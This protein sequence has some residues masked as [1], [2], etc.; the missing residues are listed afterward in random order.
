[1]LIL[2]ILAAAAAVSAST[3]SA[4]SG[5]NT[6]LFVEPIPR[7]DAIDDGVNSGRRR[8][9]R[10]EETGNDTVAREEDDDVREDGDE[11]GAEEDGEDE[12]GDYG[13]GEQCRPSEECELCPG[14]WKYLAEVGGGSEE[15]WTACLATGRRVRYECVSLFTEKGSHEKSARSRF[16]YRSC[17]RTEADEAFRMLRMQIAC[18]LIGMWSM[19]TVRRRK[20]VSAS[21]FDQRRMAAM[22]QIRGGRAAGEVNSV[23]ASSGNAGVSGGCSGNGGG[24]SDGRGNYSKVATAI[25]GSA[26]KQKVPKSPA[27]PQFQTV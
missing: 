22:R 9:R 17:K 4:S 14:N 15:D 25:V 18:L 8:R 23:P 12:D 7:I 10:A 19:R 24:G 26:K 11:G 27:P 20:R 16:E 21:L 6:P 1:M 2:A 5:G 13:D 3:S